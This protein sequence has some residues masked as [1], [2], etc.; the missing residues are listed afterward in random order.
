[1][2]RLEGDGM[3]FIHIGMTIVKRVLKRGRIL[4]VDNVYIV[5]F[6]RDIYSDIEFLRSIKNLI[7]GWEELFLN[8]LKDPCIV[9]IYSFQYINRKGVYQ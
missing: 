6:L 9:Y 3:I 2:K 7:F 4:K 1:M 5:G 8:K